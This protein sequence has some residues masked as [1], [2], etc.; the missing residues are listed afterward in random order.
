MINRLSGEQR[1]GA[2]EMLTKPSSSSLLLS[3]SNSAGMQV[4]AFVLHII[5]RIDVYRRILEYKS[6]N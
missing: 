6:I 2:I 4:M 3:L 5:Y 1:S